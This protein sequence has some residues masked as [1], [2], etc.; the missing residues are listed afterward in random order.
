MARMIK[1]KTGANHDDC[2]IHTHDEDEE[3]AVMLTW[4]LDMFRYGWPKTFRFQ[5]FWGPNILGLDI[6]GFLQKFTIDAWWLLPFWCRYCLC[7][8]GLRS[9]DAFGFRGEAKGQKGKEEEKGHVASMQWSC[10]AKCCEAKA[11][12]SRLSPTL[13]NLPNWFLRSIATC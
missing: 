7:L 9:R 1:T 10:W 8:F 3:S 2:S 11:I 4:C 12:L 5:W 6:L 13:L